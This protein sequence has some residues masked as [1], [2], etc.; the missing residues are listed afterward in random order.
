LRTG[1]KNLFLSR[2]TTPFTVKM[3]VFRSYAAN[4]FLRASKIKICPVAKK[5][6]KK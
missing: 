1:Q 6:A 2:K 3:P 5:V 4:I